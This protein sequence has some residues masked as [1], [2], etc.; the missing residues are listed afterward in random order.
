M[1]FEIHA[2][3]KRKLINKGYSERNDPN[4]EGTPETPSFVGEGT[5]LR[6]E[7]SLTILL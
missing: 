3:L 5:N 4:Q 6:C 1:T 2:N 7:S